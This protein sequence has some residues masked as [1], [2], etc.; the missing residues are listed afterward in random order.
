MR[1]ITT[2]ES[3]PELSK[4]LRLMAEALDILDDLGAP[5]EIGSML[6][7]AF[8]RLEQLLD[9]DDEAVS[10]VE[11]LMSQLEGELT[12]AHASSECAPSPWDIP[13]VR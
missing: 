4:A 7:L 5:G 11:R 10:G 2:P 12:A 6:D 9:R 3:R 1:L 8:A 13:P